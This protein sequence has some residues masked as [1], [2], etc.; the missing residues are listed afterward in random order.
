[1]WSRKNICGIMYCLATLVALTWYLNIEPIVYE[2]TDWNIPVAE[3]FSNIDKFL[4]EQVPDP[5]DRFNITLLMPLL[6]FQKDNLNRLMQKNWN[7]TLFPL[8]GGSVLD[9]IRR[10]VLTQTVPSVLE[11]QMLKNPIRSVLEL[12]N[13][14]YDEHIDTDKFYCCGYFVFENVLGRYN[15]P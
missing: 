1:M 3:D 2:Q 11:V 12:F 5:V 8:Y 13:H 9:P 6:K 10:K 15:F 7:R 4:L 14:E